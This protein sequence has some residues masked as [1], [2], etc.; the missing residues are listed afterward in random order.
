MRIV[1]QTF[2]I[3]SGVAILATLHS[4]YIQWNQTIN[5]NNL[6]NNKITSKFIDISD[7]KNEIIMKILWK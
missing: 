5:Q 7:L 3:L 4:Y 1:K 2:T 6:D